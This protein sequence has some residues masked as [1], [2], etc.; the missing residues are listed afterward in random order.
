MNE[1]EYVNENQT[2]RANKEKTKI[3]LEELEKGQVNDF[4]AYHL[5]IS[6]YEVDLD[7]S[8]NDCDSLY[9]VDKYIDDLSDLDEELLQVRQSNI[10]K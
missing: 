4:S 5:Q 6:D 3:S 8:D 10:E 1:N 9:D 7:I 2:P